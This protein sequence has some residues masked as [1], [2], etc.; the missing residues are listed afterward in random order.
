MLAPV[1]QLGN[2]YV[3]S[4]LSGAGDRFPLA[5]YGIGFS[6]TATEDNTT[7]TLNIACTNLTGFKYENQ[8]HFNGDVIIETLNKYENIFVS[9]RNVL[10][11]INLQNYISI[12]A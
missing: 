1:S 4:A 9:L 12:T 6:V 7:V 8:T 2:E 10:Y 5:N 3:V 11:K